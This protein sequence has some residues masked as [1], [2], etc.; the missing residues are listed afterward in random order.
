MRLLTLVLL[1][2]LIPASQ[3]TAQMEDV[4][5]EAAPLSDTLHM[6]TGQG[7]K[8]TPWYYGARIDHRLSDNRSLSG[9]KPILSKSF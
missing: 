9:C 4:V 6:L 2:L 1:G 7:Y 8:H 5:I 3:A